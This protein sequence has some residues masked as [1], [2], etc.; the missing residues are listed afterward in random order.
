MSFTRIN[1]DQCAY[2]L[3]LERSVSQGNYRLDGNYAENCSKCYPYNLPGT[4]KEVA[5]DVRSDCDTGFG[6]LADAESLITNR[7]NPLQKCNKEKR[8]DKYKDVKLYHKPLCSKT[9]EGEDTRFTNPLDNYRGM[10]LTGFYFT[11]YLHVN[12]QCHVQSNSHREGNST[13]AWEDG[14]AFPPKL[15][16]VDKKGCKVCCK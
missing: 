5:S 7:V 12:P 15:K 16:K 6:S 9:L 10:S 4:S 2:D 1:Y 3:K 11:P 14:T 8:N 13:R